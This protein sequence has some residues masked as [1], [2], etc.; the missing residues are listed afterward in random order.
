MRNVYK[1][2][3]VFIFVSVAKPQIIVTEPEF[4]TESDSIVVIFDATQTGAEEL[5][6]YTG[7]VYAH[8]GVNTN[9]GMW[10]HVI[11]DWGNNQ[12][13]PALE[14]L[15]AN[16]YRLIIGF[17]RQFYNVTN[18]SEDI[19][20][21]SFVFRSADASKQTRPDI[22]IAVYE[23]GLNVIFQSPDASNDY[24]DPQRSPAFVKEDSSLFID[25]RVVEIGTELAQ[26]RLYI[27]GTFISQTTADSLIHT[28]N[29]NDYSPGPHSAIAVGID[30]S[31][32]TD[33]TT[34]VLF[35]N[36]TIVNQA[37]P[38]GLEQGIN[39]NS[40]T[41]AT[42]IL[43]APYKEFVYLIGDFND[44][45]VETNYFLNRYEYSADNVV[46][47]ITINNLTSGN[48]YAFQYLVDGEIRIGDPY[49][50]K[51]LDPWND[52]DISPQT[53]PN[54]KPYPAGKTSE[55]VSILQTDQEEY[56]WQN[57]NFQK[58][59]NEKLVIYELL[60]RDFLEEHDYKTLKDTLNYLKQLGVNAI[61]LMPVME[62]EGNLSWGYN[63][64]YHYALDK[65][66]GPS[67]D[68]KEFIDEAHGIGIAVIM[69]M[70]LNHAFGHS[71]MVRLY[72]DEANSRPAANNPWFNQVPKHPYNV[73]YDFNHESAATKYYVDRVNKQWLEEYKIDGFRFDLSKGFTQ[74]FSSTVEQWG[75]YDQSRINILKRMADSIWAN[76]SDAYVILEHFAANS[77]ETVLSN[78]GMML[79][80]NMNYEYNEATMGYAS[81]LNGA[82]YKSRGWSDMHLVS[83]MESHDEER[84][85]FKNLEYGNSSGNYNI[86]LLPI[87][88]QRM[89]LAGTFYFTIPGPKMIWQFGEMGYDYSINYPCG[90]PDCRLDPKPIRWDYF[91]DGNR[92]NLYKVWQALMKLREY[93]TFSTNNFNY[94]LGGYGKRLTLL[95][96]TM[97][98]NIIGNFN[99]VSMNINPMFPN[100]GW[101]YDYFTGDSILVTD[102]QAEF[103]LEPGEFHIY[104][105]AKLPT[106]EI[107]ILLDV[108]EKGENNLPDSYNLY[109]N[110]PNPFNPMTTIRYSILSPDLVR[111]K[112]YDILGIE[113]KTLVNE[114]KQAG[115]YEVQFDASGLAS[116]IYLYRIESGSFIQTRKM[117]VLK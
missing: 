16:L 104:T 107:G 23:P 59:P 3:L 86:Q 75:Q 105:T 37:P 22:F 18:S 4:P 87:A 43:F 48:E 54:L 6:N 108:E 56:Q 42:L 32:Q 81:N 112:V 14:R 63:P 73:G 55:L 60:L 115:N 1:L 9:L 7:T 93:E 2:I 36:P 50:K 25:I 72:W 102:T 82:T 95:D 99:V 12:T 13:Q 114:L 103:S 17:P 88:I 96:S 92:K 40:S 80:G 27:D 69:D 67:N 91:E 15:S 57:T 109:Q 47:W 52:G 28:V 38:A 11:G 44:W 5:L 61:E 79:W 19:S 10:Q 76:V 97:N 64:S 74:T 62:F 100:D 49:T 90:T 41:S 116:G 84:L 78:Y 31:G 51:I 89:K 113:V 71:P 94:S 46:W 45:K 30:S 34:I 101:W 66:Y 26:L 35:F 68:F 58:P 106:P 77:E 39:S 65:Y 85:M 29:Y 98:V 117:I 70:V 21:L 8:T 83:Y 53:Y 111:I 33:S 110:F 20:E 24:G